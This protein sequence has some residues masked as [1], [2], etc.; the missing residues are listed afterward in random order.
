MLHKKFK[1]IG[2]SFVLSLLISNT[3]LAIEDPIAFLQGVTNQIMSTLE[4]NS[5]E[6]K[7][8]D[9][10]LFSI[11]NN[12]ILPHVDFAEMSKWIAGRSAWEKASP[13]LKNQFTKKLQ[14]LVV[15][16]Y[17]K[18]LRNYVGQKIEFKPLRGQIEK[19]VL[20]L[21][22]VKEPNKPPIRLDYRLIDENGSWKVYDLVIEGVSL[23]KGYQ[24]QFS[25]T[26]KQKGLEAAIQQIEQHLHHNK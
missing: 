19:R 12:L 24:S 20:V 26:I 2:L 10:K 17:A 14:T 13:E 7:H 21:S 18:A 22:L 8:D 23:L 6:I 25:T 3:V 1:L 16:T 15:K 4:K 11:V 5:E 9:A